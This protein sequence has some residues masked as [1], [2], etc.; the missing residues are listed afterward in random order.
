M[1]NLDLTSDP[2]LEMA[3]LQR[4]LLR[5]VERKLALCNLGE[6]FKGLE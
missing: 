4:E 6:A 5:N 1:F 2:V 3:R